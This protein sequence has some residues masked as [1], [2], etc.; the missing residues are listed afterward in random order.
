MVIVSHAIQTRGSPFFLESSL[1]LKSDQYVIY[2]ELCLLFLP[3]KIRIV[4]PKRSWCQAIE[5][6]VIK[7]LV[8]VRFIVHSLRHFVVEEDLQKLTMNKP[9]RQRYGKGRLFP[10]WRKVDFISIGER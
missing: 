8:K 5:T 1:S 9:K 6:Q 2:L 3:Y 4:C 7:L 10:N